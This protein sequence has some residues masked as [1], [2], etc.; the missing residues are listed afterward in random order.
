MMDDIRS[1]DAT[2]TREEAEWVSTDA[3][4]LI[5]RSVGL[6]GLALA[7]GVAAS[8]IVTPQPDVAPLAATGSR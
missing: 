3:I 7:I 2:P 8:F 1:H 4:A 6:A 5:V